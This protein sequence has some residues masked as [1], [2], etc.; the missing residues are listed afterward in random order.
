MQHETL[1]DIYKFIVE[2]GDN[3]ICVVDNTGK[4]IIYNKKMRELQG[5]SDEEF[6]KRRALEIVG[7][8]TEKGGLLRVLQDEQPIL[9]EKKTF[10]NQKGQEVTLISNIYPLY[11]QDVLVGAVEFAR[12]ITQ[13]EYMMYQPLRR[14]NEPLTFEIIT[15]ISTEMKKVIEKAKIVAYSR[16]PVILVGE[17]GTGIDMIA[18]GIH[19][20][21]KDKNDMFI[22]LICRRDEAS[23]ISQLEK[24]IVEKKNIT[25][26]AERIEYLSKEAQEKIV[27]LL[28]NHTNHHHIFI[29]SVG[30]DPF[31]LIQKGQLSKALYRHFSDISIYIP[32]L[33]NRKEDIMPFVEDYFKRHRESYGSA[34]SG[35]SDEVKEI[36][37]NYNWPGNLKELEVLLDDISSLI[38]TESL[39]EA[40]M[41]PA[42]FK[43][44]IQNIESP[45]NQ[46]IAQSDIFVVM[47]KNELRP[48][49]VYMNEVEDYYISRALEL[50]D[51][52][53]S[54]TATALGI[55]RQSLQYRIRKYTESRSSSDKHEE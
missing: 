51:G 3:G 35:L 2:K 55:K 45:E 15:A 43:W 31:D 13:Q 30:E 1:L 18:E 25:F 8:N 40:H 12:D 21:L 23:V 37:L 52:N 41:L 19:H 9:N 42:H 46:D 7:F 14:Y 54:K 36:F 10:W 24:Y 53:V 11:S 6:E 20:E 17:S 22:T 29:A 39:V 32:A 16:M 4:L 34:I 49:D 26:F 50:F 28:A 47:N 27:E 33:R 44:K 38:T 48:L 5:I